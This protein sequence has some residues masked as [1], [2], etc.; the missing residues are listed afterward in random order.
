MY[1]SVR[2]AFLSFSTRF[3]GRMP[4]MYLDVR[5]L[6]TIGVGNLIDPVDLALPLPFM[7]KADLAAA[8]QDEIRVDWQTV[9]GR[10]DL[11][12]AHD[13]LQQFD[14]LT[15]LK[16]TDES[17]DQIVLGKLDSNEATLSNTPEFADLDT[18]PVDAQLGL[19]SMAWAAGSGFGGGF[20]RFRAACAAK[21]W[22]TAA[23]E[24][25]M[26]D[27]H[28]PG[29]RPRNE[30]NRILFSNA[31]QVVQQNLDFSVLQ[32]TKN[33]S[34]GD[35]PNQAQPSVVTGLDPSSRSIGDTVTITGQGFTGAYSVGFGDISVP[36]MSVDLDAQITVTVPNG[37]GNVPVTVITQA[38]HLLP[39]NSSMSSGGSRGVLVFPLLKAET[40]R[41]G[42]F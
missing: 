6:V 8:T 33:L 26:D 25:N 38:V 30:A 18:W 13:Y 34:A 27:T 19:F 7:Q 32:Y 1:P 41:K 29:L 12:M 11:A 16:L 5:G 22:N 2:A 35:A 23:T 10:Q 21:D 42:F 39:L 28:N 20:L 37:S 3:E 4:Y 40:S 9:K 15:A 14:A 31:A 24:S 36:T 17:I